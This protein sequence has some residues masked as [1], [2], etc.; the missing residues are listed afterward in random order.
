MV[1]LPS[2]KAA[3]SPVTACECLLGSNVI[4]TAKCSQV[5]GNVNESNMQISIMAPKEVS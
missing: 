4:A 1:S 5:T 2:S 3:T